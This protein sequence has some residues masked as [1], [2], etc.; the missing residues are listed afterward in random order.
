MSIKGVVPGEIQSAERA[1]GVKDPLVIFDLSLD[2]DQGGDIFSILA[3]QVGQ[4]PL[5][6]KV[7]GVLAG[8]GLHRL[9]IDRDRLTLQVPVVSL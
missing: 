7:H 4:Q 1:T 9:L 5:E 6:V 2:M 8:L 3:G